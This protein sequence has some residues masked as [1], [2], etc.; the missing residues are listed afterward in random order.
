MATTSISNPKSFREEA[1]FQRVCGVCGATGA[2]EAHHVVAKQ[3]L[4]KL[5]FV[6]R[7]YDP[8]NALRLCPECHGRVTQHQLTI[9]VD[10]LMPDNICFIWEVLKQA[11]QNYLERHYRSVDRRYTLHVEGRCVRCQ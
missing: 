1:Q 2:F 4:K 8:R 5:G 10:C 9:A 6:H 11:G 7:L 3:K